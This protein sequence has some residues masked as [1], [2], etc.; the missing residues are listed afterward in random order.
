MKVR[1][2]KIAISAVSA[3]A[4]VLLFTLWARSYCVCDSVTWSSGHRVAVFS[5]HGQ[6]RVS[7]SDITFSSDPLLKW[8][9]TTEMMPDGIGSWFFQAARQGMFVVFPHRLPIV[10]LILFAAVPWI[11]WRYS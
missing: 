2:R 6:I 3:L 7:K 5:R 4:C 10:V 9:T 1:T 8:R 11:H